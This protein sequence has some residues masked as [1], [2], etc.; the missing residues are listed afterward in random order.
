M[1]MPMYGI[2]VGERMAISM[3][4][5]IFYYYLDAS[6]GKKSTELCSERKGGYNHEFYPVKT[7]KYSWS[8]DN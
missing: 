2:I 8:K 1:D 4:K 7:K 3:G 6:R 5:K